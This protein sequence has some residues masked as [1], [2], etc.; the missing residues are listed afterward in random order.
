M[1]IQIKHKYKIL[2]E[3]TDSDTFRY[4]GSDENDWHKVSTVTDTHVC[5]P[6]GNNITQKN[7]RCGVK[8]IVQ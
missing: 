4:I 6:G 1:G 7:T 8:V 5:Y 2:A 3:L